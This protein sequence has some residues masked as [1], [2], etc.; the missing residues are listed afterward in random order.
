MK[1]YLL[2][3]SLFVLVNC[4]QNSFDAKKAS[5]LEYI[6]QDDLNNFKILSCQIQDDIDTIR[7]MSISLITPKADTSFFLTNSYYLSKV[8][9]V[10]YNTLIQKIKEHNLFADYI[11]YNSLGIIKYRLKENTK[12][13]ISHIHELIYTD[14]KP[15]TFSQYDIIVDSTINKTWRYIYYKASV[16]H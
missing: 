5:E 10:R 12:N 13:N 14:G 6:T 3:L 4:N 8:D 9:S 16:G 11:E 2:I 15:L 7:A 1:N